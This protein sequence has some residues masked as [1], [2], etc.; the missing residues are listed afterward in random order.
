VNPFLGAD[1]EG[2][3]FPGAQVPFGFAQVGPDMVGGAQ[4]GYRTGAPVVGFSQTK[5]SGTG[6]G[7]WGNVRL[8]PYAGEVLAPRPLGVLRD[9][10][11]GPG[12]YRATLAESAVRAELTADRMAGHLR[13]TYP[14]GR[15]AQLHLDVTSAIDFG[16]SAS[17]QQRPQRVEVHCSGDDRVEGLVEFAGGWNGGRYVLY[18]ALATGTPFQATTTW[19]GA[20]STPGG[21]DVVLGSGQAAGITLSFPPGARVAVRTGL[22][23]VS[24]E[25]ARSHRDRVPVTR[26]DGVRDA[27]IRQWRRTLRVLDVDGGTD[28]QRLL[29]GS[30]LR[31]VHIGIKDI[32]GEDPASPAAGPHY[33]DYFAIWDTFRT[34]HPLLTL[35]QPQRQ[36]DMVNSLIATSRRLGWT[37]DGLLAHSP[38]LTQGGTNAD[39]LVADAFVKRLDGVHYDDALAV[40]MRDAEVESPEPMLYGRETVDYIRHGGWLPLDYTGSLPPDH[41]GHGRVASRT[42]EY[43]YDDFCVAAVADG[44]GRHDDARR[45]RARSLGWRQLW[46]TESR[47]V[48]PRWSDGRFV[49][50]YDK[51]WAA[52]WDA[53]RTA[54]AWNFGWFQTP[55]YEGSAMNYSTFVPHDTA[56]LVAAAGGP[57]AFTRWLDELFARP[58][59]EGGFDAGNEPAFLAPWLYLHA[60]RPDRTADRVRALLDTSF[61]P[62]RDGWPGNDDSGAMSA[63]YIFAS[64]GLF[65]NAGQDFYYLGSPVF[66]EAELR[67]GEHRLRIVAEGTSGA[68]RYVQSASLDGRPLDRAWI[69]HHE[70]TRARVLRFRMGPRP[71][72]WGTRVPPPALAASK[73]RTA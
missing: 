28:A 21:R 52:P 34:V 69:R 71:G 61:R 60:G 1:G 25:R 46:D 67:T 31:N 36:R 6:G 17:W 44:L 37:F 2:H 35:L 58:F 50:P 11:A 55:Y 9:E 14:G 39:V 12:W 49:E 30:A 26:F 56:A 27:A 18:F 16:T 4:H 53:G 42:L 33:T 73:G 7:M 10:T 5:A 59:Y 68:N 3:V 32:T 43:N 62:V 22:S 45:L 29:L 15:P 40:M 64:L 65:P 57:A 41:G 24:V 48:R 23:L 13:F 63:L 38:G 72:S 47:S 20:T 51:W 54:G 8:I 19:V 66:P 70:L